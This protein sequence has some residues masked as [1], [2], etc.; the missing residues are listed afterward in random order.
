MKKVRVFLCAALAALLVVPQAA[1]FTDTGEHWARTSIE[2]WSQY[3]LIAGYTDGTFG[4]DRPVTRGEMAA[5]LCGV[6]GW[7]DESEYNFTDL[8]EGAWYTRYLLRAHEMGVMRG[9]AGQAWPER[10]LTRQEAAVMLFEA[11]RLEEDRENAPVFSDHGQIAGWAL[12]Q[13]ET[14]ASKGWIAGTED[15]SFQPQSYITRAQAVT[16]LNSA[17]AEY[18]G[19]AGAFTQDHKGT[20]VVC[21][22]GVTLRNMKIEGDLILTPAAAGSELTLYHVQVAGRLIVQGK[23]LQTVNLSGTTTVN[24]LWVMGNKTAVEAGA[25]A[26]LNRVSIRTGQARITGIPAGT[27]VSVS[28]DAE[29]AFVNGHSVPAGSTGTAQAGSD[30][31]IRVDITV[32]VDD[33]AP[34]TEQPEVLS[35]TGESLTIRVQKGARY[36]LKTAGGQER[37]SYEA[38]SDGVYTF[39]NL[40]YGHYYLTAQQQ[41]R[42]CSEPL[43]VYISDGGIVIDWSESR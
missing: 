42:D 37:A 41:G 8:E 12:G 26:E 40:V 24:E 19:K 10:P 2:R 43:S 32:D 34:K 22:A 7:K 25:S 39:E 33:D 3:G 17:I 30:A 6:F 14:L 27:A 15:G 20:A 38:S 13:V 21:A 5:I 16:I 9:Y 11:L 18:Y 29:Q 31:S 28:K 23:E 35:R 4:P 36:E 1:A